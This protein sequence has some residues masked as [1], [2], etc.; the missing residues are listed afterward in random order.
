MIS[1]CIA[2]F[3]GEKFIRQ[4]LESI[5]PQL[6]EEDEI[7]VSDNGSTD[8]TAGIIEDL[9]DRRIRLVGYAGEKSPSANFGNALKHARGDYIFLA[10]QDDVWKPGKVEACMRRLKEY[11]CIVHD[12]EMTD[13]RLNVIV[14]SYFKAHGT[15][16]NRLYNLLV[17]NGYMGCCM[18]FRRRV[19]DAALPFPEDI[20]LHDIWI[21][22]TAAFRYSV[23][24]I[25]DRLLLFR[26]HGGNSSFT[27]AMKSKNTL[28]RK[29]AIRLAVVKDLLKRT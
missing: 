20:P 13:S 26:C 6:G 9:G 21:G 29:L 12:A 10:D 1:V 17:K 8:G 19:L 14:K 22:N 23:K 2:S 7:I 24:F 16:Q 27:A 3:N 25:P 15:R 11:D 18:A 5:I 4:Q 28:L